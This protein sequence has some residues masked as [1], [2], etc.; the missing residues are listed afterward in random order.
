[1]HYKNYSSRYDNYSYMR[2]LCYTTANV[3]ILIV[4]VLSLRFPLCR[5]LVYSRSATRVHSRLFPVFTTAP[6]T[7]SASPHPHLRLL[8]DTDLPTSTFW[9]TLFGRVTWSKTHFL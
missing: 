4:F 2:Q 8:T 5:C 7:Q 1:M 6:C 3:Y 9:Y